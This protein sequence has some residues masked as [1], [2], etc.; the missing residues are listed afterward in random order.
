MKQL[1]PISGWR[2]QGN[3]ISKSNRRIKTKIASKSELVK[4]FSGGQQK[5]PTNSHNK[6]SKRYNNKSRYDKHRA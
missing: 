1:M 3:R 4:V 6:N 5:P 2:R